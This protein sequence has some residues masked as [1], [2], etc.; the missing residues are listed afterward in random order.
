MGFEGFGSWSSGPI[1]VGLWLASLMAEE[2]MEQRCPFLGDQT[3]CELQKVAKPLC[4][5]FNIERKDA[6]ILP[7][8]ML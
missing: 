7:Q 1:V 2:V 8:E 3:L 6:Q 4:V 5:C